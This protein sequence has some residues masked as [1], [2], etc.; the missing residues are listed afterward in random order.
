MNSY[1][2][3]GRPQLERNTLRLLC[4]VLIKSGTR[5]EICKLLDPGVFQDPLRRVVF[6]E[7][8][9]LGSIESRRLREL[10]PARVTHRGFPEFDLHGL[11]APHEVGEREIDQLF[12]S[13]L[14]LLD[15][16]HPDEN[17][18]AE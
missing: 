4:S 11:L 16:S 8:R 13:A 14:Q 2:S 9:E 1:G 18:L 6:E 10:L 5:T 15:L 12:E 3:S 17:Q 7:I